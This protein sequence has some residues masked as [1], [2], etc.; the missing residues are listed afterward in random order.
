[1]AAAR[2]LGIATIA[3]LK[4]SWKTPT[5]APQVKSGLRKLAFHQP[6]T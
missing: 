5:K 4:L 1:M 3:A 2:L 6:A